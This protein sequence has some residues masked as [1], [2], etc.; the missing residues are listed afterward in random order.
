MIDVVPTRRITMVSSDIIWEWPEFIAFA[1]RLGIDMEKQTISLT[2]D[3]YHGDPVKIT[4]QF[5]GTD[6]P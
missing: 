3:V 4:Q 5:I 2:I 6:N 1:R